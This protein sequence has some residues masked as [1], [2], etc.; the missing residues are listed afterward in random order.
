LSL[1]HRACTDARVM[2][3]LYF[4]FQASIPPLRS[5]NRTPR[6]CK[7]TECAFVARDQSDDIVCSRA[8][9]SKHEA[10]RGY[11]IRTPSGVHRRGT[12]NAQ[13]APGTNVPGRGGGGW[14]AAGGSQGLS[15]AHSARARVGCI[16]HASCKPC[17]FTGARTPR[18]QRWSSAVSSR[19][20]CSDANIN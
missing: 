2:R 6:E 10:G 7:M 17:K 15:R 3:A 18:R 13:R 14:G 5:E 9:M 4:Y 8:R 11:P 1:T 16:T 20:R 19:A 12:A